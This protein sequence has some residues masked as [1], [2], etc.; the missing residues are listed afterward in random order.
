MS[1]FN[2]ENKKKTTTVPTKES[3]RQQFL[4]NQTIK[5][6]VSLSYFFFLLGIK[7]SEIEL[8]QCLVFFEVNP[9]PKKTCP[10]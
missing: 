6:T 8:T 9:S 10:K 4:N 7:S 5:Q 1:W 3:F 2:K